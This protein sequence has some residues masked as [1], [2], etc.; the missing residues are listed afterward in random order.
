MRLM[1]RRPL[2]VGRRPRGIGFG[3]IDTPGFD[4]FNYA[5]I[6]DNI[7]GRAA[8]EL[9]LPEHSLLQSC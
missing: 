4:H 2:G 6:H 7:A 8:C 9:I 3:G 1:W 5:D